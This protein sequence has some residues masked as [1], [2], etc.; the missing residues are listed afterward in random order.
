[1]PPILAVAAL[2]SA[3]AAC[4]V[5]ELRTAFDLMSTP[6]VV[7]DTWTLGV[8]PGAAPCRHLT[9]HR[10]TGGAL[11]AV[12]AQVWQPDGGR[13]IALGEERLWSPPGPWWSPPDPTLD[14]PE[15]VLGS[16]IEV[17]VRWALS[18]GAVT[19][20]PTVHGP[21]ARATLDVVG[22]AVRGPSGPLTGGPRWAWSAVPADLPPLIVV[23]DRREGIAAAA[24]VGPVGAWSAAREGAVVRV[25]DAGGRERR[26][27]AV[28]GRVSAFELERL[29]IAHF[30]L[31]AAV[32][33]AAAPPEIAPVPSPL[34]PGP[35]CV[36]PSPDVWRCETRA[37]GTWA[38]PARPHPT[39]A[40]DPGHGA[41]VVELV[42]DPRQRPAADE[43]PAGT[44]IWRGTWTTG[45][46]GPPRGVTAPADATGL[47]CGAGDVSGLVRGAEC[48]FPADA[49]PDA[50]RWWTWEEPRLRVVG[51]VPTSVGPGQVTLAVEAPPTIEVVVI[52]G[53]PAGGGV[54]IDD[55]LVAAASAPSTWRVASVMGRPVLPDR[56]VALDRVA[57][58]GLQASLPQPGLPLRYKNRLDAADL[59]PEILSLVRTR[60][61]PGRWSARGPLSPRR[62]QVAL[63]SRWG[64]DWEQALLLARYLSEVRVEAV[65][66]PARPRSAG[67]VEGAAPVGYD[68]ALVRIRHEGGES[69][70]APACQ[71]CGPDEI[72]PEL[73]RAQAMSRIATE[74]PP[75]SAGWTRVSAEAGGVAVSLRGAAALALRRALRERPPDDRRQAIA[76]WLGAPADTAVTVQGL[77]DR[78]RPVIV[79][80]AAPAGG[81]LDPRTIGPALPRPAAQG[82]AE[83]MLPWAGEWI[84]PAV[85]PARKRSA[86][87]LTWSVEQASTG[88]WVETLAVGEDRVD[89]AT[90]AA[91]FAAVAA[92]RAGAISARPP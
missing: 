89:R 90:A 44:T 22:G 64:T 33:D 69:W 41:V 25:R 4:P 17:T 92:E 36:Q 18:A 34:P 76:T 58:L 43:P 26:A 21:V 15:A 38:I 14:L 23:P 78:G 11:E 79:H 85:G 46:E 10:P 45:S 49:P 31:S 68:A 1:M 75:A 70:V 56:A 51:E 40:V 27:P 72:P 13:P 62:L 84:W 50:E 63:R 60:L 28:D 24:I 54:G 2:P 35:G 20:D 87:D 80:L 82:S 61:Q 37:G 47:A 86:G 19:W 3:L 42:P 48:R 12:H 81:T 88:E 53:A 65:P 73:G 39:P 32:P 74:V 67:A 5:D 7:Q 52:P 6:P 29:G 30:T 8:E 71:L 9:L 83:V 66:V 55:G 91:F 16:T 59:L 77:A 57:F